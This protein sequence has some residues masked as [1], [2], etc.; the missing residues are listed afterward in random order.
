MEYEQVKGIL[1]EKLLLTRSIH[2]TITTDTFQF[3]W[4]N[5]SDFERK[6]LS[7]LVLELK[8]DSLKS[9]LNSK[10]VN[11]TP[12]VELS[13]SKLRRCAQKLHIPNYQSKGKLDLIKDI[14]DAV[15]RLKENT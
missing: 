10:I 7:N 1:H 15:Q 3:I 5:C 9:F 13:V 4:E 12:F 11:L 14:E 2:Y 6:E 8:K